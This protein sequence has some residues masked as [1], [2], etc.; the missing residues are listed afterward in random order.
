MKKDYITDIDASSERRFFNATLELRANADGTPS[1]RIR[2]YAAV[3]N[4]D[5][6]NFGYFIERV[7]PGAFDD[8]L[9][10]EVVALFNHDPNYPLSRTGKGLTIGIDETGLWYEFDAPNTTAGNDLLENVRTGVINKSSFA[11]SVKTDKWTEMEGKTTLR[12][13]V[14]VKRL[15]DVSP[16]TYAG[17]PD[18]TVANRSFQTEVRRDTVSRLAIMKRKLDLQK[19]LLTF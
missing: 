9:N 8:V 6:E 2:G 17:Y 12:E 3:F 16:V 15:Y 13:I 19:Q 11:F 1:R 14:K 5:S 10:D 4:R 18:T 7:L